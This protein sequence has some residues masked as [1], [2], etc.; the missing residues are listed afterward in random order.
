M[1][2]NRYGPGTGPIWLDDV[3]CDGSETNFTNC[4]HRGWGSHNC[5]HHEDVSIVCLEPSNLGKLDYHSATQ[6][7]MTV[8]A[9][10]FVFGVRESSPCSVL[11]L[12]YLAERTIAWFI[13]LYE[14]G[15]R[16]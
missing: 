14:G 4:D 16:S 5:G 3:E 8:T 11:L 6:H 12:S 7:A 1:I 2:E 13:G 9:F 10:E 15:L